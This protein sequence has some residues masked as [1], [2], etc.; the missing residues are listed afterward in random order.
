[1]GS[2]LYSSGMKKIFQPFLAR[3]ALFALLISG[4]LHA[5]SPAQVRIIPGE[6]KFVADGF[7]VVAA[8][9]LDEPSPFRVFTLDDPWRLV[10]DFPTLDWNGLTP[11]IVADTPAL[12]ALRF[13]QFTRDWSRLVFDLNQPLALSEVEFDTTTNSLHLRLSPVSAS[14]FAAQAGAPAGVEWQVNTPL[15]IQGEAGLPIVAI[16]AGHGGVDPGAIRGYVL[17]KDLTLVVA[18]ELRTALLA[19]GRYRVAMIRET[20]TFVSLRDRV[21][22][23]RAAGAHVLLSLHANTA[24]RG[25]ARGTSVY[26]LSDEASDAETAAIVEF[27][28]RADLLAGIDLDGE[29]DL[30]AEILVDMAQRETNLLSENLG[31]MLSDSLLAVLDSGAKSRHRWAGFRVLKAPDIPSVLLELGFMSTPGDLEDMQSE[32]WRAALNAQIIATLDAWF[33]QMAETRALMRN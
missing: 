8:I 23:A 13:G 25:R 10:V 30:I 5:Q 29:E 19:T 28:N 20:D 14:A 16:D 17:E 32:T 22:L 1:M 6:T 31:A 18:Q 21:R 15:D 7:G 27:E 4:A 33:V 11:D 3:I 2:G 26:N 12:Q 9:A 24:E